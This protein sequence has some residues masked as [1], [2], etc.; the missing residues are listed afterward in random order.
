MTH[1]KTRKPRWMKLTLMILWL[2]WL[3]VLWLIPSHGDIEAACLLLALLVGSAV[4]GWVDRRSR[5][6]RDFFQ[7]AA[8][9]E[10]LLLLSALWFL[11]QRLWV[12]SWE[13][14]PWMLMALA[15]IATLRYV[16][17]VTILLTRAKVGLPPLRRDNWQYTAH[18]GLC[19]SALLWIL[20]IHP[21]T[22]I[23]SAISIFLTL[24]ASLTFLSSHYR[25]PGSRSRITV[26]TQ[27]TLTRIA[28]AP[29]FMAVF[30]YD[31]NGNPLDNS[32]L[33]LGIA[34]VMAMAAAFTDWL[35]GHLARKWGEVT[36]LGKY[37]D[38]FSD[39]V[40]TVTIFLCFLASGWASVAA[41]ALIIYRESAV[42][43]LRTLAA[44]DGLVLAARRSGKWKTGI[45]LGAIINLLGFAF[46]YSFLRDSGVR[47][48]WLD[49]F[50]SVAPKTE[51]WIVAAVT[52]LSGLD[53]FKA[54]WTHL[55]RYV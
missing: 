38:P 11:V 46:I 28:M 22:Q 47:W 6:P 45:Q 18:V 41:V 21:W 1:T 23:V 12:D 48:G 9:A 13:P 8:W 39:K 50:W 52:I 30:F 55:E 24:A 26:A 20:E 37:L 16:G 15:S 53:Y 35:D 40:V 17:G 49:T 34:F 51:M 36:T 25:E 3:P 54:N 19:L 2:L 43:T 29:V 27:I 4:L 44:A 33:F 31:G 5:Q 14:F 7:W 32:S 42:E 10:R